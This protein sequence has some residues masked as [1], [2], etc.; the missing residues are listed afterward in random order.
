[1]K[2]IAVVSSLKQT[3][4]ANYL[5]KAFKDLGCIV[6]AISDVASSLADS[7]EAGI[8]SAP[9]L[10]AQSDIE[11]DLF[12][13]IEGG[14][15]RI[16]PL[17][18]ENFSCLTAWYG[19]DTHM[20]YE[21]HL[22]I[23]R[24]FDITFVA[25]QEYVARL[26][27]DGIKQVFWLPLAFEPS[28]HPSISS[29]RIYDIA[30]VGSDNA[31]MHSVRHRIL[32]SLSTHFPNMWKGMAS[33]RQMGSIYAQSK[34]VFNKSVNNDLNMRYFEAMGAGA[35]L[36]TDP[37]LNNGVEQLFR[38]GEHFLR[39]YKEG[40]VI[41]LVKGVLAQPE[42]IERIGLQARTEVLEK[43]TYIHRAQE[44]LNISQ[45]CKKL[46]HPHLVDYFPVL[47]NLGLS[48]DALAVAKKVLVNTQAGR[49]QKLVNLLFASA[50]EA[51]LIPARLIAIAC[52]LIWKK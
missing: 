10:C 20:D 38:E 25:Q 32:E 27:S 34:L 35:V 13:F 52:H 48:M 26:K 16:F 15:M 9:D 1:M 29:E 18:L 46:Q 33:P 51:I 17:G 47:I 5:I 4:T 31:Q 41:N 21:K 22:R 19:I 28:L 42:K 3:A 45:E 2:T 6:F 50:L 36:I 11:P 39:Y 49:R 44:I 8:C 23:A 43:H 37:I 24:L 7:I 14:S 30:Y 40:E 12:L